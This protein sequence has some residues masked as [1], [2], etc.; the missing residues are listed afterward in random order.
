MSARTLVLPTILGLAFMAYGF[1]TTPASAPPPPPPPPS[2]PPVYPTIDVTPQTAPLAPGTR[3]SLYLALKNFVDDG[4][5]YSP[6]WTSSNS[7]VVQVSRL[8]VNNAS[9][10]IPSAMAYAAGVGS[11]TITV[12][13]RA[14]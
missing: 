4:S 3:L 2:P 5:N 13:S 1:N 10:S 11:A 8:I 7:A 14:D 12:W 6:V 9:S